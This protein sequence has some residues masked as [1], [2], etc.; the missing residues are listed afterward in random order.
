M[1]K[2]T[3]KK[4]APKKQKELKPYQKKEVLMKLYPKE[5]AGSIARKYGVSRGAVLAQ[6]RKHEIKIVTRTS[7]KTGPAHF[8][9]DIDRS[10]HEK[11]FLEKKL[12]EGLSP[13]KIATITKATHGQVMHF[14]KKHDLMELVEK[15][16]E[17]KKKTEKVQVVKKKPAKKV[18]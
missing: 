13:F 12:K 4:A 15:Q 5:S 1:P 18:K 3:E 14:I 6:L 8:K 16:R 10:F 2:K 9:K 17:L 11:A 7:P